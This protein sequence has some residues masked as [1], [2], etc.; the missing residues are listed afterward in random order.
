[1]SVKIAYLPSPLTTQ[2]EPDSFDPS[3]GDLC[4]YAPWGNICIFYRDF[5]NSSSLVSLGKLDSDI[6]WLA[7]QSGDFKMTMEKAAS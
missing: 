4:Y 3:P 6:Q 1:M 2:G 5:R 7:G